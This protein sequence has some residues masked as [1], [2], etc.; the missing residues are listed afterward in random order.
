MFFLFL[1]FAVESR[2]TRSLPTFQARRFNSMVSTGDDNMWRVGSGIPRSL[3]A[4]LFQ[5]SRNVT[6]T[7]WSGFT[8]FWSKFLVLIRKGELW[9]SVYFFDLTI[10]VGTSCY[11]FAYIYTAIYGIYIFCSPDLLIISTIWECIHHGGH[12]IYQ[13]ELSS[14]LS[15]FIISLC[16]LPTEYQT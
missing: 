9:I 15:Q 14:L 5:T 8:N 1:T 11:F 7:S 3:K 4:M 13:L 6:C 10:W 16:V 2:V 12:V